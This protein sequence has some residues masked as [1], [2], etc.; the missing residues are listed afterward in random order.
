MVRMLTGGAEAW[1]D[2]QLTTLIERWTCGDPP[3]TY[4]LYA[5]AA[6]VLEQTL[7]QQQL[8]PAAGASRVQAGDL[9]VQYGAAGSTG[10]MR[11]LIDQYWRRA[12]PENRA[13]GQQ[14]GWAVIEVAPP[15]TAM[16]DYPEEE[17]TPAV[18]LPRQVLNRI[19]SQED[20]N[21]LLP[22]LGRKE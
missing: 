18:L 8:G 2:A 6:V 5:A 14:S 20:W 17:T 9:Q 10:S 11:Y 4:D 16:G 3:A 7:V 21:D 19:E 22:G 1:T 15:W 13:T 12:C